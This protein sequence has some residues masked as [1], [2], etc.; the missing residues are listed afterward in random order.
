MSYELLGRTDFQ[1]SLEI[2]ITLSSGS[3]V[4][5]ALL[6]NVPQTFPNAEPAL[7]FLQASVQLSAEHNFAMNVIGRSKGRTG[8]KVVVKAIAPEAGHLQG[9]VVE[10]SDEIQIQ[11]LFPFFFQTLT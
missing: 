6:L 1:S 2:Q 5:S 3:S 8:L 7:F 9:G 11:V 10:L 4:H